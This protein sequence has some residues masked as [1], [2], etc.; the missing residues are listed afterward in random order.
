MDRLA[1][2]L[3]DYVAQNPPTCGDMQVVV[4][5]IYWAYMETNR[6]DSEKINKLYDDLRVRINLPLREYDEVLYTIGDLNLEYG[7]H[8]FME[9]LKVAILLMQSTSDL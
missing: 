5:K 8:A 3:K 7:R 6:M 4:D 2:L 9:G 1:K